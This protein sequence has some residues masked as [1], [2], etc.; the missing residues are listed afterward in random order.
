MRKINASL[1]LVATIALA[2]PAFG[3]P[4]DRDGGSIFERLVRS[5]H[6]IVH[7]FDEPQGPP[8]RGG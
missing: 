8:P 3:A 2:G 4:R 5:L 7:V 1:L 6:Q